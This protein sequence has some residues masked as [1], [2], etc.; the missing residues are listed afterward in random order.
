MSSEVYIEVSSEPHCRP[1]LTKLTNNAKPY[2]KD[3]FTFFST[4]IKGSE[5]R[6]LQIRAAQITEAEHPELHLTV[7]YVIINNVSLV[8]AQHMRSNMG[9]MICDWYV[10]RNFVPPPCK[11]LS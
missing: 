9:L 6:Q 10:G 11:E 8:S 1:H 3:I 2:F 4:C 5:G 7:P